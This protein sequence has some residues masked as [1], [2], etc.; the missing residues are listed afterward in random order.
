MG[1]E[2]TLPFRVN[3]LSKRAPSATR[4]SLR[5][6]P[7]KD[8]RSQVG[9]RIAPR[10]LDSCRL[11]FVFI[12]WSEAHERKSATQEYCGTKAD[13]Q[14]EEAG[15]QN[16]RAPQEIFCGG[17][18]LGMSELEGGACALE[19]AAPAAAAAAA[20]LTMSPFCVA[21]AGI[22]GGLIPSTT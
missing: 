6:K 8:D 20:A 11:G 21:V 19:E 3:T 15:F 1:F 4:P 7:G 10:R 5:R 16:E 2:P 9:Y 18:F 17:L 14:N 13:P 12:L 22:G